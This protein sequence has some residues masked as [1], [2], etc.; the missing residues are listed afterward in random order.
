MDCI[1]ICILA[2][3]LAVVVTVIVCLP[4]KPPTDGGSDHEY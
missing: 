2:G 3:L 4:R 1:G